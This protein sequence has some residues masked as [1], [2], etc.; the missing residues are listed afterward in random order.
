MT[1]LTANR[2]TQ[3][4]IDDS[5]AT[6]PVAT[7]VTIFQG[8]IVVVNSTGN[9]APATTATGL[10][11]VGRST[12]YVQNNPGAAGA[13]TVRVD[14]GCFWFANQAGDLVTR[15]DLQQNCYLVDDQTVAR[16]SATSTRSIAGRVV[17]VDAVKGVCVEL[18]KPGLG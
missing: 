18:G 6:Y 15:A 14:K 10:R 12:E 9:A 2:D 8:S 1:A 7:N 16:T 3:R 4:L 17:D 5:Q 13:K 11:A